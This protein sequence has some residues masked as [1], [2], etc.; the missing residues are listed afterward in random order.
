MA[1][2]RPGEALLADLNAGLHAEQSAYDIAYRQND[3]NATVKGEALAEL[4]AAQ[5]NLLQ[6][7]QVVGMKGDIETL[8]LAEKLILEN[9]KEF[10]ADTSVMTS[11][12][13]QALKEI[14]AAMILV[15]K[16]REPTGYKTVTDD[17][18]RLDRVRIKGLPKD[19]A[20]TFFM[21][22]HSR[23]TNLEKAR[24]GR[25]DKQLIK[26]RKKNLNQ[27]RTNYISLQEHALTA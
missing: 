4:Q 5:Y 16:V 3:L 25:M 6:G 7:L 15:G 22:H 8:L 1:E 11:S 23:L 27:A 13:D 9:E 21:S 12:L 18:Y 2:E 24:V 17:Y 14:D 10:Y 26:A 20:R 19:L